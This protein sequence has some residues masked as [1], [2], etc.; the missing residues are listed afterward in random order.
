MESLEWMNF[1]LFQQNFANGL[2]IL[3]TS[4]LGHMSLAAECSVESSLSVERIS[5]P[6][7]YKS[8]L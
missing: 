7:K 2:D 1:E 4:L 8:K 6:H 5:N 3:L